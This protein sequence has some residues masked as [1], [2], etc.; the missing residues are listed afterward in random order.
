MRR[1]LLALL[2]AATSGLLAGPAFAQ[3]A[4]DRSVG[5]MLAGANDEGAHAA[6]QYWGMIGDALAKDGSIRV[7]DK[8]VMAP[9]V[10]KT[11]TPQ[12]AGAAMKVR[13][14][15]TG[16][17][18]AG[19]HA[20]KFD[21]KMFDAK[22]G[23]QLWATTFQSDEDNILGVPVEVAGSLVPALKAAAL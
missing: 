22:D 19:S 5:I 15:L 21:L 13:F 11:M 10:G 9:L 23:K 2:F 17:V 7:A 1:T 8:A 6:E 18:S 4:T 14:V 16:A 12:E 3:V 20:F